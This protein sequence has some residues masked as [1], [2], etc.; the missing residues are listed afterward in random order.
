MRCRRFAAFTGREQLE[1]S[2]FELSDSELDELQSDESKGVSGPA[3]YYLYRLQVSTRR[4][5]GESC[6]TGVDTFLQREAQARLKAAEFSTSSA[7]ILTEELDHVD[8]FIQR[9]RSQW[10]DSTEGRLRWHL[11]HEA[12]STR[13]LLIAQI[14]KR[15]FHTKHLEDDQERLLRLA[16]QILE[17]ALDGPNATHMTQRASIFPFVASLVLK[18]NAA[19]ELVLRVALRMSGDPRLPFIST[20]VKD[21][22]HALL[23]M[24]W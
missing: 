2:Q 21:A 12:R 20:F 1:M 22:G 7:Y 24:V 10:C 19:R 6:L 11:L 3:S 9:W 5:P 14:A 16:T 18:L 23:A 15:R 8:R 4:I 13:L 17:S